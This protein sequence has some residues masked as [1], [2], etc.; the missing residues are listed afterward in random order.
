MRVPRIR[1]VQAVLERMRTAKGLPLVICNK[2]SHDQVAAHPQ[3]HLTT[4]KAWL[5]HFNIVET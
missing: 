4:P 2:P 5:S 3:A 1:H